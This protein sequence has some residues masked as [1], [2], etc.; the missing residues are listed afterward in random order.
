MFRQILLGFVMLAA[1]LIAVCGHPRPS[2]TGRPPGPAH[3]GT[4]AFHPAG[5]APAPQLR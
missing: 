2:E 1:V 3:T 5:R 4:V